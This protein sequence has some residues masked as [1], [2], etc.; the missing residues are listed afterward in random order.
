MSPEA[1]NTALYRKDGDDFIAEEITRG[2]WDDQA[3]HGGASAA[4]AVYLAE[5][6]ET[7]PDF[8]LTRI[9]ME[10]LRP[11]PLGRLSAQVE[12]H[13]GRSVHRHQI[14]LEAGGKA[15]ARALAVS[16]RAG[17][18]QLPATGADQPAMPGRRQGEPMS[19]A[20]LNRD[21]V[22]FGATAMETAV[23]AG[24]TA[25]PGPAAVWFRLRVPVVAGEANS[26]AMRT[27]AAADFPN[28]IAWVL[29][30]GDYTFI[31][32]DLSVYLHREPAGEWIGVDART[33]VP[34]DGL[35]VAHS[36]LFDDEGAVGMGQ[37]GLI[38]RTA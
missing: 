1:S 36:T 4:L 11:V 3:Q 2:P 27:L 33:I 18:E 7:E 19:I 13:G 20:G 16:V 5:N 31:N 6:Q 32:Y 21:Q 26:P 22:S 17:D 15:V 38:I 14:S 23:V 30:F 28:G 10:L 29:P 9:T 12:T 34:R 8:R 35:G 37:Q 25:E 24:S